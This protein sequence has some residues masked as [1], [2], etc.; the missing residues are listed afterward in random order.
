M[1]QDITRFDKAMK[2]EL[3]IEELQPEEIKEELEKYLNG[4]TEKLSNKSQRNYFQYIL[5]DC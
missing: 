1:L 4:Y 5:R 3:K 2:Q